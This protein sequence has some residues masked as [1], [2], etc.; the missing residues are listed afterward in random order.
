M[1]HVCG[2]CGRSATEGE[3]A[4]RKLIV[5]GRGGYIFTNDSGYPI[6]LIVSTDTYL[7]HHCYWCLFHVVV[8]LLSL[9]EMA[10]FL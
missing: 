4:E 10:A 7:L 6:P 3:I 1:F 2:F 9:I 8:F 5:E